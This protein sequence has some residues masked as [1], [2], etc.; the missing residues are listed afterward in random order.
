MKYALPV[1]FK[2]ANDEKFVRQLLQWYSLFQKIHPFADGNGRIGG[3]VIASYH[4]LKTGTY[5]TPKQ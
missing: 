1:S 4:Y 3:I 2:E 5:L